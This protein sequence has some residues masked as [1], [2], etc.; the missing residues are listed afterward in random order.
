M[1]SIAE[2]EAELKAAQSAEWE[3]REAIRKAFRPTWQFMFV[4]VAPKSTCLSRESRDPS[5]TVYRLTGKVL[6]A[7]DAKFAGR[8]VQRMEG[9]MDYYFNAA[10]GRVVGPIGGGNV[11]LKLDSPA[12][13]EIDAFLATTPKGGDVTEIV[14]PHC[15]WK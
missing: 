12:W 11:Y 5:V 10:S 2:I 15:T 4:P 3:R 14:T 9:G 7:D 6:N 13:N 8:D 1:R